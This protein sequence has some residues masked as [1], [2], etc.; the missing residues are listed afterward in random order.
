M[1]VNKLVLKSDSGTRYFKTVF[2]GVE[3]VPEKNL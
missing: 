3:L 1:Y 2:S